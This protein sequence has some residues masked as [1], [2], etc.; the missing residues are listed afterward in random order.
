MKRTPAFHI[1]FTATPAIIGLLLV[2]YGLI[3][4]QLHVGLGIVATLVFMGG[5]VVS[6]I[7]LI[8]D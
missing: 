3:T 5:L 1:F 6:I 7:D 4:D 8:T 2:S